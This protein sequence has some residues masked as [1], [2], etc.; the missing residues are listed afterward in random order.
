M[1]EQAIDHLDPIEEREDNRSGPSKGPDY[2]GD[3]RQRVV[4]DGE[5]G[6]LS[7]S[8]RVRIVGR[9]G[10]DGEA[11]FRGADLDSSRLQGVEMSPTGQHHDLVPGS[12]QDAPVVAADAPRPQDRDPHGNVPICQD[13]MTLLGRISIRI[14]S[15]RL[16]R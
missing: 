11:P 7:L 3:L 1:P 15:A 16:S 6:I 12:G 13:L 8:Q 9:L 2:R 5:N 4:L 14:F 10:G